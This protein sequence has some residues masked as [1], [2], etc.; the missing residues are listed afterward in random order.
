M[1]FNQL[2]ISK[3]ILIPGSGVDL[4]EYKY[5]KLPKSN[6]IVLFQQDYCLVSIYEFVKCAKK[7]K[8]A[9]F[10]IV[11]KHD[12]E[13]RNCIKLEELNTFQEEDY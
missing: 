11:G 7:L 5:S 12:K 9:R 8:V 13:A 1:Q 3:T 2:P 10:V 6:P 4:K